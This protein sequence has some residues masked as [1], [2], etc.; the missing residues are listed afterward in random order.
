MFRK[1]VDSDINLV[2]L[3]ESL[4]DD[5][6]ELVAHDREYLNKWMPW[7]PLIKTAEDTR[8][9]INKSIKDFAEGKS[10][11]CA[12]EYQH[13]IVGV[14]SFN[15]I[16]KHLKKVEIGFWIS[17]SYQGHGIVTRACRQMIK[18]AFTN[19]GMEKIQISAATGNAASRNVCLRLGM[20][21]EGVITNAENLHGKIVNHA[22][23]GLAKEG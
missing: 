2:F 13:R 22:V 9:F 7:S 5:L 8:A 12:I 23:Y 6:Y 18:H 11:V 17:S 1:E 4:T 15:K 14:I 20:T 10:M 16:H 19:L 3:Q 21:L